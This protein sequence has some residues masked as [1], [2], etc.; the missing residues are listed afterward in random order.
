M[1]Y[2]TKTSGLLKK[3]TQYDERYLV[4]AIFL[5]AFGIRLIS[6]LLA[7]THNIDFFRF[8]ERSSMVIN[9]EMSYQDF[10]DPKPLWTYTLAGWL[11][12]FGAT[13]FNA[14]VL[15]IFVDLLGALVFLFIGKKIFGGKQGLIP[16]L[17]YLFLPFTILFPSAEGKM[18]VFPILFV[19]LSFLCLLKKRYLLSSIFLGIGM[20]YKYLAG[21]CLI[22]FLFYILEKKNYSATLK[23][24]FVCGLSAFS[25]TLPFILLSPK[26]FIGDTLLFFITRNDTGYSF[27]HPYNFVPYFVPL[28]II[29][30]GVCLVIINGTKIK[31]FSYNDLIPLTFF[32]IMVVNIFNRVLFTQYFLYAIPFLCLILTRFV[33]EG[34]KWIFFIGCSM[35]FPL[36]I[37]YLSNFG[38]A[39]PGGKMIM[40]TV[41]INPLPWKVFIGDISLVTFV[42][43]F[44]TTLFLFIIWNRELRKNNRLSRCCLRHKQNSESGSSAR[45]TH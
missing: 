24:S 39:I 1:V 23:Y 29:L 3:I 11:Y 27:Y 6:L 10:G 22:P 36:A 2:M 32:L 42:W 38:L 43:V 12:L 17:L 31:K 26:K 30:T 4:I 7:Q 21:L 28:I 35:T 41:D 18:D 20:G 25:I 45:K 8:F 40:G 37:E 19:L 44:A 13:E 15:L 14:S 9:G 33:I 34:K 5:C 16:V